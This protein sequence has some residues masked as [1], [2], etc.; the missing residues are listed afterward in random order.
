MKPAL[1]LL[2]VILFGFGCAPTLNPIGFEKDAVLN[3]EII[4]VWQDK[5]EGFQFVV[6]QGAGSF[7]DIKFSDKAGRDFTLT[8]RLFK[9]GGVLFIDSEMTDYP[10][11]DS[12]KACGYTL[13]HLAMVHNFA[14]VLQTSPTIQLA[15]INA[16]WLSSYLKKHPHALQH[17]RPEEGGDYLILTDSTKHLNKFLGKCVK[18]HPDAFDASNPIEFERVKE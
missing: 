15:P 7:Y 6:A 13:V 14:K 2:C 1:P 4:G 3:P 17:F 18:K 8:A 16:G 10:S 11:G 5:N 9:I 12:L